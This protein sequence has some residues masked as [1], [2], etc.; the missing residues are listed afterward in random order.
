M[1]R[2][3]SLALALSA[4]L[5]SGCAQQVIRSDVTVFQDWP[6]DLQGAPYV[7]ERTKEQDNNLEY[8]SYENLVRA[9]LQ[10]LGFPEATTTQTPRIKI[11]LGY[12]VSGRDVHI[13]EPVAVD[14]YWYGYPPPF[15]SPF[16]Y[17]RRAFYGP[18]YDPFWYG[19]P[20]IEYRESNYEVFR[21]QLRVVMMRM[22]DSKRVYEVTVDSE[23]RN[24]SLA[25]AMPYMV[26]SAFTG[27]PARN[28][29]LRHIELPVKD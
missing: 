10:R 2:L 3:L 28:G 12:N 17:G 16:Y 9:E 4:L 27:F 6:A 1:K 14:P 29:E 20:R 13:V 25:V 23:G 7:F 22:E 21:R 8:R 11:S 24:P 15:R 5:L 18:F 26:R 19:P